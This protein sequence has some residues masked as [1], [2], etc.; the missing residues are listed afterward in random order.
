MQVLQLDFGTTEDDLDQHFLLTALNLGVD[1]PRDPKSAVELVTSDITTKLAVSSTPPQP[2]FAQSLTSESTSSK[3]CR[4]SQDPTSTTKASSL[5]TAS[6]LSL[7]PSLRSISLT[8]S[9][10]VK[11]RNGLRRLSTFKMQRKS[12]MAVPTKEAPR[13][14]TFVSKF[15]STQ[16]PVTGKSAKS[17]DLQSL[18]CESSEPSPLGLP[19]ERPVTIAI[20][21]DAPIE[22]VE[23]DEILNARLRSLQSPKLQKLRTHQLE[24]QGR[25]VRF[26]VEQY[27]LVASK[28]AYER[29]AIAESRKNRLQNLLETHVKKLA[30]LE[31]R[32][33]AA[34]LELVRTLDMERTACDTRL[35]HMEAYCSGRTPSNG[36]PQR[37][38]TEKDRQKLLQQ[39]HVRNGMDNLH[40]GRIN[41]LRER[42]AKQLERIMAKQEVE[43]ND[44]KRELDK[45]LDNHENQFDV[46]E[47]NL[48]QE[49]SDRKKRISARWTLIEAI[50]RRKLEDETEEI[51]AP[52]PAITWP[53]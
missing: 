47:Q 49:F 13:G 37:K 40:E 39:Y 24:E 21:Y 31:Y 9:P 8:D 27:S 18:P 34:E 22:E 36:M 7:P 50:E 6:I 15:Q 3:S 45:H 1:I 5:T 30:A 32:H 33:L 38:I 43:I 14:P 28:R 41:V 12:S 48:R 35:K 51:H 19:K 20:P 10:Y 53:D 2:H 44:E 26:E 25:F 46:E 52:L 11:I 17:L 4:S 23:S 29:T 42:Q 16:R